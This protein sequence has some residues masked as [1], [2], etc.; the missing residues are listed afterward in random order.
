MPNYSLSPALLDAAY[1]SFDTLF[2]NIYQ[3]TPTYYQRIATETTS[4]TSTTR[5]P[6]M[7][8]LQ[9][10][11][12]W[13]GER[14]VQNIVARVQE[15][16]NR[17]FENTV[18]VKRTDLEDDNISLF[19][20]LFTEMGR[21]AKIWPD[22]LVTDVLKGAEAIKSYDGQNFF[23]TSHPVNPE[24]ATSAVQSNLFHG[25]P[26]TADNLAMVRA[27]MASYK[28]RDNVPMELNPDL[29][30]VPPQLEYAARKILFGELIGSAIPTGIN[31]NGAAAT[32]NVLRGVMDLLVMPRLADRPNEWYCMCTNH[33]VKPF[34][35]QLR[36]AP[37]FTFLNRPE[38]SN[39]F[40][41]DEYIFGVRAR[42]NAGV[43]P[44][45]LA[46]KAE[47]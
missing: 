25:L 41:R 2:Q 46:A 18:R 40:L 34:I 10:M 8:R 19:A 6:F 39:V 3:D 5:H 9:E 15:L 22:K 28:T 16:T 44:Y 35:F 38:D 29:L 43:G 27:A 14:Q 26:L 4:T 30:V 23:D 1:V 37:D 42:G 11:R 36:T 12:E 13:I 17:L 24:G 45:F 47:A 33:A 32:S 20:P 31:L 7:D 21:T